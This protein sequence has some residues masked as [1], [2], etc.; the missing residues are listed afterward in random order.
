MLCWIPDDTHDLIVHLTAFITVHICYCV[1]DD[2]IA[3]LSHYMHLHL[4]LYFHILIESSDS[5]DLHIQVYVC[6][7]TDQVFGEDRRHL[8]EPEFSYLI[9]VSRYFLTFLYSYCFHN[10]VHW[11]HICS[12]SLFIFYHSCSLICYIVVTLLLP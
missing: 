4:L 11:T 2:L 9:I 12:I 6:Y 5:L 8:E 7:L 3:L 10:F 1:L